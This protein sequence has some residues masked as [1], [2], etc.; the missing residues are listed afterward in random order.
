MVV[1]GIGVREITAHGGPVPHQR[2][3]DHLRG[4]E[5]QRVRARHE[6][7]LLELVLSRERADREV[8]APL[9]HVGEVAEPVDVDQGLRRGEPEAHRRQE[10]LPAGEDLGVV[11]ELRHESDRFIERVRHVIFEGPW[12]HTV[13]SFT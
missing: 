12:D 10:A 6:G 2:I 1:G 4:V 7:R 3:G 13:R 5:Q 11:A 8:V 9:L